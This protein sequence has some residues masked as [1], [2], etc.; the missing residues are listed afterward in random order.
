[1]QIEGAKGQL[2][3]ILYYAV[4]LVAYISTAGSL[5][6]GGVSRFKVVLGKVIKNEKICTAVLVV[7][8]LC[9]SIVIGA[10]GLK[11]IVDRGYKIL[12]GMRS[13]AWFYPLLILGPISIHR[14]NKMLKEKGKID[15]NER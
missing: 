6:L 10:F 9:A 13:W 1:M 15:F 7:F 11:A 8:F 14:V 2:F 12:G 4:L 5:V 3:R